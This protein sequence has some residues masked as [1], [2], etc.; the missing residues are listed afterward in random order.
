MN[1][2][3]ENLNINRGN[4]SI[5]ENLNLHVKNK[6]F[7]GII[8]PNGSGKSTI[9]KAI[10]RVLT[11]EKGDILINGRKINTMSLK[12]TAREMAVVSQHNEMS[13]DF[14]VLDMVLIGRFPH[15]G[16][17]ER[18]KIEDYKKV[19]ESLEKVDMWQFKDRSFNTLSGG[20]KQ[21]IILAR[22][23]AQDTNCLIL[24]EPT[25]HLDIRHQFQF[26]N[27]AKELDITIITAIHDLNIATLYCDRIYA[28]KNGKI[29][30]SGTPEDII[31]E[32]LI[33]DLYGVKSKI[34]KDEEDGTLNIIYRPF[35]LP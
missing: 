18:N 7:V 11:P 3:V 31:T 6:E 20:E 28:L 33:K 35:S 14:T 26:L 24:D 17:M 23:L 8:G 19:K 5:I 4:K 25:N 1:L 16:F 27:I 29:I 15:K 2:K 9:L 32:D 21:R 13:F 10:Y 30:E 34:V 22:A 12:E